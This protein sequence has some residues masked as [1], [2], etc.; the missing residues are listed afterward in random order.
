MISQKMHRK[1]KN[2][3]CSELSSGRMKWA[4]EVGVRPLR[5]PAH[6]TLNKSAT[7]NEA[8]RT[9]RK[10]SARL[11]THANQ[12]LTKWAGCVLKIPAGGLAPLPFIGG[13]D[14][15]YPVVGKMQNYCDWRVE[16]W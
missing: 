3:F 2:R 8:G 6:L 10:Q 14:G 13:F 11:I 7:Y 12:W 9:V 5:Q 15:R 4:G 16:A 1:C